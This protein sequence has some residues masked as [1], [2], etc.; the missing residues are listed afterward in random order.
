METTASRAVLTAEHAT[1]VL[2]GSFEPRKHFYPR[3]LNAQI[4]P[5]VA[6]FLRMS[7]ARIIERYCHLHPR[8]DRDALAAILAE[9]T[10]HLQWSGT[11]LFCTTTAAGNRRLVVL[12][13][14]SCP[15][16][17][18]S[19]PPL[20]DDN[21]LAGYRYVIER[22]FLPALRKRGTIKGDLAVLFD[23]NYPE[24]SG[25]AAAIADLTGE[26]TYL[27]PFPAEEGDR[28]A[29]FNKGVLE[30][31]DH[32][33]AWR[34]IR[35]AFRYVTQRPW[36]RIPVRTRT[37]IINPIVGCLA[38]GRNK[39]LASKAYDLYNA[40]LSDTGLQVCIP[41]TIAD[42]A[43]PEIPMILE[44]F[45][46]HAV[47]KIP[48]SN[49][50]QGVFPILN[51]RELREFMEADHPYDRFVV[52]SLIGNY[53]WSSR[54]RAGQFYHVGT[55]PDR[56]GD[57]YVADLRM[58]ICAAPDGFRPIAVYGR[59]AEKPLPRELDGGA[60]SWSFL[61][62]NLS[63]KTDDG[64]WTAA[65]ERLLLMDR[66]DFNMVGIGCDD[67][68]EAF[69][70]G[71]LATKA[72]DHMAESLLTKKGDLRYKL[73]GSLDEDPALIDEIRQG[74][75]GAAVESSEFPGA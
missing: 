6:F 2:P 70:Q 51:R 22:T 29:R 68:I 25:Y 49:A 47:I 73:F 43:K 40:H 56:Y 57:I 41:E 37:R 26:P 66:K 54:Q 52:Q 39:L 30:I 46:G 53:A 50:G 4:H 34:P 1:R 69:I 48:Y 14:N 75:H 38:G 36:D 35:A 60:S 11:D 23:K 64:S 31:R 8:V 15:S 45:G 55:M 18:K 7:N 72:I 13:T 33:G 65:T 20:S 71:V 58:M 62:T 59:R 10:T 61:G 19:M 24:C 32:E 16:G 67:L 17:N 63:G 44:R 42:V 3:V 5:L 74:A 21:E 12:E 28:P 9:P 27:T